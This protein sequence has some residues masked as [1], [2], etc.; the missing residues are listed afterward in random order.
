MGT[1]ATGK[2]FFFR[3]NFGRRLTHLSRVIASTFALKNNSFRY[4]QKIQ[5]EIEEKR[6]QVPS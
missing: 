5:K 3:G 2:P 4:V 6:S 1:T